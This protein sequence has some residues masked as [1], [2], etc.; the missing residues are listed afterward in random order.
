MKDFAQLGSFHLGNY[1][2]KVATWENTPG[3]LPLGKIPLES[4]RLGKSIWEST[5]LYILGSVEAG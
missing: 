3:K 1:L 4:C 5:N 2:W